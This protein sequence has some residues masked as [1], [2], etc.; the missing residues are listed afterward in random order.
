MQ[1]VVIFIQHHYGTGGQAGQRAVGDGNA[2][3]LDELAATQ[4]RQ[5]LDVFQA[6]SATEARLRERQVSRNAQHYGVVQFVGL[7]VEGTHRGS[8]GWGVDA[9][10]DVQHFAL[11]GQAGQG[12][13][14]QA[15]TNQGKRWR[16]RA[17]LRQFAVD[18][19]RI[20]F[21]SHLSHELSPF[22]G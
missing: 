12:H 21:E 1:H 16:F 2:V 5:V 9:W 19:N 7:L 4:G 3:V 14:S 8:A 11:A 17:D 13:V 18:L 22:A 6:F 15:C 10:E 20:A